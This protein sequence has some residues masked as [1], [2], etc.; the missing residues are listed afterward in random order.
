VT[1]AVG[2]VPVDLVVTSRGL[3]FA[4]VRGLVVGLLHGLTAAVVFG[5]VYRY[6]SEREA[7][8][9]SPVRI[10]LRHLL[11]RSTRRR[12]G[13]IGLRF[14]IGLGCGAAVALTL[15]LI[16]QG[17]VTSMGLSDGQG[18][19]PKGIAVFIAELGL[20]SA[21]AFALTALLESPVPTEQ[22]VSPASLLAIDRRNVVF[23]LLLWAVAIGPPVGLVD[24]LFFGPLRGVEVGTVFALEAAFGA[25]LGYGLCLTAWGQWV[26]L[27]RIWLPLTGRLP[28]ALVAFLDDA[29]SKGVL[30]QVGAVYQFRHA[31]IQ[32]HL[33]QGFLEQ[34]AAGRR[35]E[36]LGGPTRRTVEGDLGR[37]TYGARRTP[38]SG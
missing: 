5:L 21:C 6:A 35:G 15:V 26:A 27:S 11:V 37:R 2:N 17:I 30:R 23:H 14:L 28:W 38:K 33:N 32:E 8:R 7:F 18:G 16:D 24:G 25:G 1:T 31:R 12:G 13:V 29:H 19:G 20:G 3:T 10:Q 36:P 4:L 9:P 34:Q 22:A